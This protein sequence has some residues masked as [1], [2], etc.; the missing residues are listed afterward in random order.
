MDRFF[1]ALLG[2][3]LL[4]PAQLAEMRRTVSVGENFEVGFP[5]LKYGLGLMQQ[6]LTCGGDTWGHG[7]DLGVTVRTGF[8]AD[9]RRSVVVIANGTGGGERLLG[10]ERAVRGLVDRALCAGAE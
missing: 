2:G 9:G 6:P 10:A 3:R 8:S 5:G 7:G 1:T 4:P